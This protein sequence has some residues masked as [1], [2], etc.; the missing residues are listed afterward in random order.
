LSL[1]VI[2]RRGLTATVFQRTP[3]QSFGQWIAGCENG[4]LLFERQVSC[5][6]FELLVYLRSNP[7]VIAQTMGADNFILGFTA[8]PRR[9]LS[10]VEI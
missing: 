6:V 10:S 3:W 7:S 9:L 1:W 8:R 4:D 5:C 2:G